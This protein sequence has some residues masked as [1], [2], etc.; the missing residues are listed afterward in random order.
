MKIILTG[1]CGFVG[2]TLAAE[3]LATS[4]NLEL[5]GVDNLS[6]PG[7]EVNRPILARLGVKL[8]HLDVRSATDISTLPRAD[9]VID[10]AANPSVLAGTDDRSSSR[11]LIEHNL[12]GTINLLEYCRD[13]KAGFI[14]LSTSRV[15]SIPKLAALQM[16]DIDGR[17][18][19]I[20]QQVPGFS[21]SGISEGFS[22]EPPLSLY[23]AAKF[24]SENFALEYSSLFEFPVWINRCGV[25][26]GAR[27]FGRADQG[28]F[29]FW[30]HSYRWRK[31]LRY[32]GFGGEGHQVRDCLHPRDLV[33]VLLQQIGS[34]S[35]RDVNNLGGGMEN[36]RSLWQLNEWCRNR[37]GFD[38]EIGRD[39]DE[40]VFDVPWLVLD[41]SRACNRWK[42]R[43]Q[44]NIENIFEEIAEHADANPD[45]IALSS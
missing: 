28:I 32:I 2:S 26:A 33:P 23:G 16:T 37:F 9:W 44:I 38:H 15:Y 7:S 35:G 31:P 27:Q 14:L 25:L 29:S 3:L 4:E 6:R 30:I 36:S 8:L 34:S 17:F 20:P 41:S 45:W 18:E 42:W 11:Q 24:A 5:L 1:A 19:P 43:P 21:V 10:A 39:A 40:R 22:K 13:H 12:M